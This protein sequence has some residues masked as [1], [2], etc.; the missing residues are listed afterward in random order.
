MYRP[1]NNQEKALDRR[2]NKEAKL[3]LDK[4][5]DN[6]FKEFGFQEGIY[7]DVGQGYY[8]AMCKAHNALRHPRIRLEET[9]V[10]DD[11]SELN[12]EQTALATYSGVYNDDDY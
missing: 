11:F 2:V 7:S 3:S 4:A 9:H 5:V 1:K 6:F 8:D 10:T 12:D